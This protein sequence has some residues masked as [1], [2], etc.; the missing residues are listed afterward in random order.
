MGKTHAFI[1]FKVDLMAAWVRDRIA[2]SEEANV[3][4]HTGALP[5]Y[6]AGDIL[7]WAVS[8]D[9]TTGGVLT[10]PS[11][12]TVLYAG[13]SSATRFSCWW[14][15][16]GASEALPTTTSTDTDTFISCA[17]SVADADTTD[18]IHQFAAGTAG[19]SSNRPR[20]TDMTTT[21]DDTLNIYFNSSDNNRTITPEPGMHQLISDDGTSCSLG[22]AWTFQKN[23]GASPRPYF[24]RL[25]SDDGVALSIAIKGLTP[26]APGYGDFNSPPS[27]II[28]PFC[29]NGGTTF[30]GGPVVTAEAQTP[31]SIAGLSV[32][33]VSTLNTAGDT[34]VNPFHSSTRWAVND[35]GTTF[36]GVL[37]TLGSTLDMSGGKRMIIHLFSTS[38]R[39]VIETF[40]TADIGNVMVIRSGTAWRAWQ[41]SSGDSIPNASKRVAIVIDPEDTTNVIDSS[42]TFNSAAITHIGMYTHRKLG[43]NN[44]SISQCQVLFDIN[45]LG[46]NSSRPADLTT[47]DDFARS[48]FNTSVQTLGSSAFL[49]ST[50]IKF[51][52][53]V[54]PVHASIDNATLEFAA[55]AD[56]SARRLNNNFPESVI[57]IK[58]LGIAGDFI[59]HTNSLVTSDNAY[60]FEIDA[61]STSAASWNFSG[62]TV[63]GAKPVVLRDVTTFD[64]M[65]FANCGQID[66]SGIS[67]SNCSIQN[68]MAGEVAASKI[69]PTTTLTDV[70]FVTENAADNHIEIDAAGTY[71]L[72]S[73]ALSGATTDINVTATAG[74]VTI[75]ILGGG[76]FPTFT[77]AGATVV[78]SQ[79]ATLTFDGMDAS[80][81]V[82][83]F[84]SQGG[85]LLFDGDEVAGG[86]AYTYAYSGDATVYVSYTDLNTKTIQ[87]NTA[88]TSENRTI[89]L[90]PQVNRQ[91]ENA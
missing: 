15:V 5:N 80:S 28:N 81:T 90:T 27:D 21:I 10:T 46:G 26:D 45:V 83:I 1:G 88:L 44:H 75:N 7:I 8:K 30:W 25:T 82:R 69:S 29:T 76:D 24:Y 14:K 51:G 70:S 17:V 2:S 43:T 23:A 79:S 54:D 13:T 35:L 32:G 68:P 11:G 84:T 6:V 89:T 91:Y 72:E 49:S 16:A 36:G 71:S 73:V 34:G 86:A 9:T 66:L 40:S 50:G 42:G 61:L 38:P 20:A 63:S 41:V 52:N 60:Y 3:A 85:S 22:G 78:I 87:F 74:T 19:L 62:L 33:F 18:P 37:C 55:L 58:Y 64:G 39:E 59:S 65:N 67:M 48:A 56:P 53:A 12:W 4:S 47:V 77:T 31:T 57:G